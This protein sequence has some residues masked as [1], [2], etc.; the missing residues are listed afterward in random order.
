MC[1]LSDGSVLLGAVVAQG[2]QEFE[3]NL[4]SRGGRRLG[5]TFAPNSPALVARLLEVKGSLFLLFSSTSCTPH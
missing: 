3:V 5:A 2:N 4:E 1:S